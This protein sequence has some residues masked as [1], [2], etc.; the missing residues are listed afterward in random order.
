MKYEL[1]PFVFLWLY[2]RIIVFVIVP[3]F[4]NCHYITTRSIVGDLKKNLGFS[5]V[6]ISEKRHK[7]KEI[8][9]RRP[10]S[11]CCYGCAGFWRG[12]GV[13]SDTNDSRTGGE[14]TSPDSA[15]SRLRL[16]TL[17]H[18]AASI[19]GT[20]GDIWDTAGCLSGSGSQEK[21]RGRLRMV[22]D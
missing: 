22:R 17:K 20:F 10:R 8:Q 14:Y 12:F 16:S 5:A 9:W 2:S 13:P 11:G 1:M 4:H 18:K 6:Q 19:L 7:V 21:Y 15:L 3:V